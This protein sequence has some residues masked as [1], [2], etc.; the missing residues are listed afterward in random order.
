MCV[1]CNRWGGTPQP[2]QVPGLAAPPERKAY[3]ISMGVGVGVG[4]GGGGG[5]RVGKGWRKRWAG[6]PFRHEPTHP[7]RDR[8]PQS[9]SSDTVLLSRTLHHDAGPGL[10]YCLHGY[11]IGHWR[12]IRAPGPHAAN[13]CAQPYSCPSHSTASRTPSTPSTRVP[14]VPLTLVLG[15]L[16]LLVL[17]VL[18]VLGVLVLGA[19]PI[20][21]WLGTPHGSPSFTSVCTIEPSAHTVL[22]AAATATSF[23]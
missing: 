16:G 5:G 2:R 11:G 9:I 6:L 15:V 23:F 14:L 12:L 3:A 21:I 22:V 18:G 8:P 20:T 19:K 4:T 7:T 1:S 13:T 10:Y 17:G